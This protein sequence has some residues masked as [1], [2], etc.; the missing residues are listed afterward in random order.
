M[1]F[2]L[3]RVTAQLATGEVTWSL[4]YEPSCDS[5]QDLARTAEQ[6]RELV[7]RFYLV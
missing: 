4:H 1:S 2:D 7:E 5:T 6:L 3:A